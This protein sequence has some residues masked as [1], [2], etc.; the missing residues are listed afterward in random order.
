MYVIFCQVPGDISTIVQVQEANS[1][2]I[3]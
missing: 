2:F 3:F 1:F